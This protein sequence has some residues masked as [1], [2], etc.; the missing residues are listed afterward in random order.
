MTDNNNKVV[1]VL[2]RQGD[3]TFKSSDNLSEYEKDAIY[4]LLKD[5]HQEHNHEL[6]DIQIIGAVI[7]D[8]SGNVIDIRLNELSVG[9]YATHIFCSSYGL[10]Q[11]PY[12]YLGE[13]DEKTL[14]KIAVEESVAIVSLFDDTGVE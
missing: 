4:V 8:E 13:Y 12:L 2:K 3:L 10:T 5:L 7:T 1:A 6:G 14:R 11:A 9:Y